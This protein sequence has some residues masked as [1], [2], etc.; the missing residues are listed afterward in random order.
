MNHSRTH[1]IRNSP[2]VERDQ[3]RSFLKSADRSQRRYCRLSTPFF[4]GLCFPGGKPSPLPA[5][6]A[7]ARRA[8]RRASTQPRAASSAPCPPPAPSAGSYSARRLS[9]EKRGPEKLNVRCAAR[10]I[11]VRCISERW[12]WKSA[13]REEGPSRGAV[14]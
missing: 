7:R 2:D 10:D 5:R 11:S 1:Q 9:G 4:A 6:T 12:D 8:R 14:T 13:A 3:T